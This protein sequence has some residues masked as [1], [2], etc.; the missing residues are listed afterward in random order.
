[1]SVATEFAPEVFIPERARTARPRG[2]ATVLTLHPPAAAAPPLRLT[3]R[4]LV[5]VAGLVALLAAGVVGLAALSAPPAPAAPA[6]PVPAVVT[7]HAGDTLWSIAEK[8][9]PGADPRAEVADLQRRNG[10][11]AAALRPGQLLRT[12]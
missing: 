4:G 7:V 9:A 2:E 6:A 3:R 10:L 12:R 11:S 1:M 8:V 5:V